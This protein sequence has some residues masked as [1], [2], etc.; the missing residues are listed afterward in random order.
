[1]QVLQFM[2]MIPPNARTKALKSVQRIA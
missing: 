2:A 1:M